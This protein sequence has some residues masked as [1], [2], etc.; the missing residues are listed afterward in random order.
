MKTVTLR[1][2]FCAVLAQDPGA[3]DT[4]LQNYL[5]L[6]FPTSLFGLFASCVLGFFALNCLG[7][8]FT[9]LAVLYLDRLTSSF[10]PSLVC[11]LGIL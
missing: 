9:S 6:A 7:S 1:S 2:R 5:L 3:S 8:S 11:T 4:V 10:L